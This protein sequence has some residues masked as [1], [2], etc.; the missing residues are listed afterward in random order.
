MEFDEYTEEDRKANYMFLKDAIHHIQMG[1][2]ITEDWM[3]EHKA[4]ILTYRNFWLDMSI[5]NSDN[6]GHRFRA[7]AIE[8]ETLLTLLYEEILET[9]TFTVDTYHAFNMAIC[10]MA[11]ELGDDSDISDLFSAVKI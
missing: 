1:K 11:D 5:L 8:A 4:R 7:S 6:Q 9:K 2:R 3:E 10:R